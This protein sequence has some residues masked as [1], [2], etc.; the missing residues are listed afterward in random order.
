[1]QFAVVAPESQPLV[2]V[3]ESVFLGDD[4][5]DVTISNRPQFAARQPHVALGQEASHVARILAFQTGD[6]A[7]PFRVVAQERVSIGV[8]AH[9][10]Q[11]DVERTGERRGQHH[12]LHRSSAPMVGH[13]K[14]EVMQA[15]GVARNASV[16]VAQSLQVATKVSKSRLPFA[17]RHGQCRSRLHQ[18]GAVQSAEVHHQAFGIGHLERPRHIRSPF[19]LACEI[20]RGLQRSVAQQAFHFCRITALVDHCAGLR[21]AGAGCRYGVSGSG[22]IGLRGEVQHQQEGAEPPYRRK[23]SVHS[24]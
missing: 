16:E 17:A 2:R 3:V 12:L 10:V 6:L 13:P 8:P 11:V 18:C 24:V 19:Q 5:N 21:C 23:S 15:R 4:R 22:R 7:H 9:V 1:M 14:R 20:D